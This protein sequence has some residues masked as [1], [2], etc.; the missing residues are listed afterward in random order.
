[1]WGGQQ[2]AVTGVCREEGSMS[3]AERLAG[4]RDPARLVLQDFLQLNRADEGWG[5]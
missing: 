4:F 5:R 3:R 1:L 2:Q